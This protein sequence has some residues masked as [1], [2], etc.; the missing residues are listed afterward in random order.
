M[1]PFRDL[2][3]ARKTLILGL[4]PAIFAL[5]VAILASLLST[6][7][8]ARR[9][10]HVDVESQATV[11]ADNTGAGLAFGD[12]T[13]RR[14][15]HRCPRCAAEHRHGVR[16]RQD[17]RAVQPFSARP[18]FDVPAGW[19]A[20]TPADG[21]RRRHS[22]PWPATSPSAP[23]TSAATMRPCSTGCTISRW[24]ASSRS[25]AAFSSPSR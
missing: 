24:S 23:S 25:S 3:I 7:M 22:R 10:Q 21:P 4:V 2:P 14:R 17:G 18:D 6:Y 8:M 19:P 11:V 20:A 5:L 12:Q 9:N 16:L 13:G 1:R 15:N